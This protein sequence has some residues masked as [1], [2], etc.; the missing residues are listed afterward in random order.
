MG[1]L[2]LIYRQ[3]EPRRL[4]VSWNRNDT[5]NPCTGVEKYLYNGVEKENTTNWHETNY[6]L[7]DSETGRFLRLDPL[8]MLIPGISTYHFAYN[9][10][11]TY[12]DPQ[13]LIGQHRIVPGSGNHW[14]DKFRSDEGNEMLMSSSTFNRFYNKNH[15]NYPTP[16]HNQTRRFE[17]AKRLGTAYQTVL[18]PWGGEEVSR[19]TTAENRVQVTYAG[20]YYLMPLKGVNTSGGE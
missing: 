9:N 6:R 13:G 20:E 17:T 8:S 10:P 15:D 4:K 7:Y 2:K 1:C 5:E 11:V 3:E 14:S 12:N 18:N 19:T 16:V